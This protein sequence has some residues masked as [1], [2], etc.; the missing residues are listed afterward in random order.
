MFQSN[1]RH[2]RHGEWRELVILCSKHYLDAHYAKKYRLG[3]T[4]SDSVALVPE[5]TGEKIRF[6]QKSEAA[7]I[8]NLELVE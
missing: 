8:D 6:W 3:A 1:N 7:Q 4:F 5:A 2:G